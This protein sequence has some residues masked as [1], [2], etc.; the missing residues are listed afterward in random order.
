MI[1]ILYK[2]KPIDKYLHRAIESASIFCCH[3]SKLNDIFE[4]RYQFSDDYLFNFLSKVTSTVI[5]DIQ[6]L[7]GKNVLCEHHQREFTR[8]MMGSDWWMDGFFSEFLYKDLGVGIGSFTRIK[9]NDVMWGHYADSFQGVC[10]EF[11][12]NLSVNLL[13][14]FHPVTYSD[15]LIIIENQ[16]MVLDAALRKK[17]KWKYE[18]EWRTLTFPGEAELPFK[19]ESLIGIYFGA[20]ANQEKKENLIRLLR[21]NDYLT[22]VFQMKQMLRS[23]AIEFEQI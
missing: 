8:K 10:L 5:N 7:S 13:Q 21:D 4:A 6:K 3:Q 2:Y 23:N 15:Q 1:P 12:F 16:D 22:K 17:E 20:N 11:D 14:K 19:K 9:D 18:E